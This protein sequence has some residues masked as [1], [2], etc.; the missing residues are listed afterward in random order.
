MG[1]PV[2]FNEVARAAIRRISRGDH[3]TIDGVRHELGD[4]GSKST[5]SK[6]LTAWRESLNEQIDVLPAQ[7]PQELIE[8]LDQFWNMA[9]QAAESHYSEYKAEHDEQLAQV[10][11]NAETAREEAGNWERYAKELE[12]R[13]E[14]QTL[15][16]G[17]YES[18]L[19]DMQETL[20]QREADIERLQLR[21]DALEQARENEREQARHDKEAAL[22]E[23]RN[24]HDA[25]SAR[26]ET[27]RERL[28][29]QIEQA[30]NETAR[31]REWAEKQSE[32]AERQETY[33]LQQ[34]EEVR[35]RRQELQQYH[36]AEVEQ[37]KADQR[38]LEAKNHSLSN[39]LDE[40]NEHCAQ[41]KES[42]DALERTHAELREA[43]EAHT[44]ETDQYR[45]ALRAVYDSLVEG[46]GDINRLS[47]YLD[48]VLNDPST[49]SHG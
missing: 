28:K 39:Q 42:Y 49:A 33:L 1:Q 10:Q 43:M 3:A 22:E 41:L 46:D 37:F 7:F 36:E 6:H 20:R 38:V 15:K 45:Q 11:K 21:C 13:L 40:V 17:Q 29:G 47:R 8:P 35:Q 25:D 18:S 23:L 44:T 12:A 9:L 30:E 19:S 2:T 24:R 32:R 27:E 34:I 26:W 16:V 5:I 14:T 31:I 48:A 4:R